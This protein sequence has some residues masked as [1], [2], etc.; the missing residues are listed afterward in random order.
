[1]WDYRARCLRVH[2][3]DTLTLLI[4]QGLHSRQEEQIRLVDVFA[5]ELSQLGGNETRTFAQNWVNTWSVGLIWP[6]Y[7]ITEKNTNPEPDEKRTFTRYI[8]K[9]YSIQ[10]KSCL[11]DQVSAFLFAHPEWGLGVV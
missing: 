7:V 4:D 9:V 1:M 2:D 10:S 8:G 3:G 5:P 6:L 11:N